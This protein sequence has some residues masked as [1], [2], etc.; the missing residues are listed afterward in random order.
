MCPE[1]LGD[2][3][4]YGSGA[5]ENHTAPRYHARV[6][7]NVACLGPGRRRFSQSF[8]FDVTQVIH[9]CGC[10]CLVVDVSLRFFCFLR[11]PLVWR[12]LSLRFLNEPSP[13]TPLA[14]RCHH[15]E[16]AAQTQ[17]CALEDYSWCG[18]YDRLLTTLPGHYV[19]SI[20]I[21]VSHFLM[22]FWC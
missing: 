19:R 15:K 1:S 4:A 11:C 21:I 18:C 2:E 3:Y 12:R 14:V 5:E 20:D 22:L 16:S 8:F 6:A 17:F 10:C 13:T 7:L 9:D